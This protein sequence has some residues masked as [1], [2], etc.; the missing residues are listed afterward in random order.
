MHLTTRRRM[1]REGTAMS[2]RLMMLLLLMLILLLISTH[3][4]TRTRLP[5]LQLLR[6]RRSLAH[7]SIRIRPKRPWM[8]IVV[9]ARTYCLLGF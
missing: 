3:R 6:W 1:A 7:L 4:H 9:L 2:R 8:Q 5:L